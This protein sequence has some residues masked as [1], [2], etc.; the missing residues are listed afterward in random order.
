M[1]K[2]AD[3][4]IIWVTKVQTWVFMSLFFAC[5]ASNLSQGC[6]HE[7]VQSHPLKGSCH[8][9][10]C[11]WFQNGATVLLRFSEPW[12]EGGNQGFS[13]A[14]GSVFPAC[15]GAPA[16]PLPLRFS[17]PWSFK[18]LA[19]CVPT[20]FRASRSATFWSFKV[21]RCLPLPLDPGSTDQGHG[22]KMLS[23]C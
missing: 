6:R 16:A 11:I 21:W 10:S 9:G 22:R 5:W 18:P 13:L 4:D 12:I 15:G 23:N 8:A 1:S 7:I 2:H 20:S 17:D 3:Q 19:V 14:F